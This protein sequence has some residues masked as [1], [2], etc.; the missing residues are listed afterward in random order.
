MEA[1]QGR[2]WPLGPPGAGPGTP[3]ALLRVPASFRGPAPFA[4]TAD[5]SLP[6]AAS[7]SLLR[8]PAPEHRS[9]ILPTLDGKAPGKDCDRPHLCPV[10]TTWPSPDGRRIGSIR[11]SKENGV[12]QTDYLPPM[13]ATEFVAPMGSAEEGVFVH[14]GCCHENTRD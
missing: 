9:F 1:R 5:L 14:P 10:T 2:R 6:R 12:G 13:D 3:L 8:T 7:G 11:R 4:F